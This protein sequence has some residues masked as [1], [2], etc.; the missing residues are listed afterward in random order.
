M[1]PPP[2]SE[3]TGHSGIN[4]D[5]MAGAA[6]RAGRLIRDQVT[7]MTEAAFGS[8]AQIERQAREAADGKRAK[9]G[10]KAKAI[11]EAIG[12]IEQELTLLLRDVSAAAEGLRAQLDEAEM[13]PGPGHQ[14]DTGQTLTSRSDSVEAVGAEAD[15]ESSERPP[16]PDPAL[17]QDQ[18]PVDD[19]PENPVESEM[20]ADHP[21]AE[22][23]AK[24][25]EQPPMTTALDTEPAESQP[26]PSA[27]PPEGAIRLSGTESELR[28]Q[29]AEA[30]DLGLAELYESATWH[31]SYADMSNADAEYWQT[32][33]RLTV[34]EAAGRSDEV[35]SRREKKRRAKL[36]RP[37]LDA[38]NAARGPDDGDA[39][40]SP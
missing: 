30:T 27:S 22:E 15:S 1:S 40:E 3:S 12:A 19:A 33:V 2:E 38:R 11:G 6:D 31:E 10:A 37:L 21:E 34:E 23:P 20:A 18:D 9:A 7:A 14:G 5:E 16:T 29:V 17:E 36:L 13:E 35:L 24:D 26:D 28:A 8:A 32:L 39:D 4:P 25:E